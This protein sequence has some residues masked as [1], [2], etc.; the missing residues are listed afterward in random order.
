VVTTP[1][2]LLINNA[3]APT[4]TD[5]LLELYKLCVE[6]ADRVSARRAT[7][8]AFFL[9][10]NSALLAGLGLVQPAEGG[11]AAFVPRR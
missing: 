9:T 1:T 2:P 7:A 3:T 10:L 5:R 4:G 11:C 6:M 8:N